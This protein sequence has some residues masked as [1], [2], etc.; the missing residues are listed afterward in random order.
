MRFAI[1]DLSY[2]L[3]PRS[4]RSVTHIVLQPFWGLLELTDKR[5]FKSNGRGLG[6]PFCGV[7]SPPI[8]V[9]VILMLFAQ[10]RG[11]RVFLQHAVWAAKWRHAWDVKVEGRPI[12][13]PVRVYQIGPTAFG[14]GP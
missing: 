3:P 11:G 2:E 13:V 12:G 5:R 1:L 7:S 6:R 10:L 4:S 8:D 9:N 14:H